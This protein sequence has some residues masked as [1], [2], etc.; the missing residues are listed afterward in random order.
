MSAPN[1]PWHIVLSWSN[2]RNSQC[3]KG[4][5]PFSF[6]PKCS[7]QNFH[8]KSV[9]SIPRREIRYIFINRDWELMLKWIYTNLLKHLPYLPLVLQPLPCPQYT[10]PSHVPEFTIHSSNPLSCLYKTLSYKDKLLFT[11]PWVRYYYHLHFTDKE[12]GYNVN[13]T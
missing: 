3:N 13:I 12:T 10:F 6:L 1:M 2:L 8:E 7:S 5:Q 4:S 11:T 9:F